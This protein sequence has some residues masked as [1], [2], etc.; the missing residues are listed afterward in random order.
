MRGVTND[1]PNVVKM[2][3]RARCDA[4]SRDPSLATKKNGAQVIRQAT[5]GRVLGECWTR[6]SWERN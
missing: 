3:E 1:L 4:T 5:P 6:V 2:S